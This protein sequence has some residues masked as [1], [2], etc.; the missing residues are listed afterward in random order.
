MRS[1]SE[2]INKFDFVPLNKRDFINKF[3]IE[4]KIARLL[5]VLG[6]NEE[7]LLILKKNHLIESV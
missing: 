4:K 7:A 1:L 3:E 5:M 6:R 2:I